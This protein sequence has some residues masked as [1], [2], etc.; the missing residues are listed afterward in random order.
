MALATLPHRGSVHPARVRTLVGM[1]TLA[2]VSALGV[3]LSF[4]TPQLAPYPSE[5]T[6][7]LAGIP[8]VE[9]VFFRPF[10]MGTSAHGVPLGIWLVRDG[11]RVLALYSH[12]D[13]RRTSCA[14]EQYAHVNP[15]ADGESG[16]FISGSVPSVSMERW[17][18][19]PSFRWSRT[20][21][22]V[23]GGP[24]DMDRFDAEIVGDDV[25]ID[26]SRLRI[27]NCGARVRFEGGGCPYST[28]ATPQY[29]A[30]RWPRIPG[31]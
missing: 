24:R 22:L 15:K 25:R 6:F 30:T 23:M 4:V 27:G 17:R 12:D 14:I 19:C 18:E 28:D 16:W 11:D 13:L 10:D 29:R 3:A 31:S 9:P 21:V 1:L 5:V 7:P 8:E 20:G 26:V 2:A